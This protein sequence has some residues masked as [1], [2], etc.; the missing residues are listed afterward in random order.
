[1]FVLT[2]GLTTIYAS[3]CFDR[4]VGKMAGERYRELVSQLNNGERIEG[5]NQVV[6]NCLED[7]FDEDTEQ[8]IRY[9]L[10]RKCLNIKHTYAGET[11]AIKPYKVEG[12]CIEDFLR[13]FD[14][15]KKVKK[16]NIIKPIDALFE[17]SLMEYA[18]VSEYDSLRNDELFYDAIILTPMMHSHIELVDI[19]QVVNEQSDLYQMNIIPA[20]LNPY[21]SKPCPYDLVIILYF[22]HVYLIDDE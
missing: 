4:E 5:L 21:F 2:I 22:G 3:G 6:F 9:Y 13:V 11:D 8:N 15:D 16:L 18:L 19:A 7:E 1:M 17:N 20:S 10:F 14:D 12:F